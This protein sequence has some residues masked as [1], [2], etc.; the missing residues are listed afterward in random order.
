M[1]PE[2]PQSSVI[3]NDTSTTLRKKTKLS[4]E[5]I[6]EVAPGE[7]KIPTNF[8]ME[9][10]FDIAGF[11]RHFPDGKGGLHFK[12]PKKITPQQYFTQRL[13]N[14]DKRFSRDPDFLFVAQYYVERYG[15]KRQIDISM[16]KGKLVTS[17]D[18]MKVIQPN[19]FFNIFKLIPGTPAYWKVFRNEIMAK[20][21]QLGPFHIFFTLSC[22]EMGWPEIAAAILQ[23]RNHTVSFKEEFW[24]GTAE[25]ILID[26]VPLNEY[27]E[28]M[29]NKSSLFM[30][31]VILITMMFDNRVKAFLKNILNSD[32]VEH[33]A[34]R[35]E[36]QV[37]GMPHVHGVLWLNSQVIDEYLLP[38]KTFD[39]N[40]EKLPNLIDAWSTCSLENENDKLNSIVKEVNIH[41]H[42]RC[43]Q[44]GQECRFDFPRLPSDQTLVA[45]PLPKE[46][47]DDERKS[48]LKEVKLIKSKLNSK[49]DYDSNITLDD[50]LEDIGIP[51]KKY[52]WALKISEKG[53]YVVLKRKVC[54][55]FVNNYRPSYMY[56]WQ[57]NI[58]IQVCLDAYSVVSYISDYFTKPD[59]GK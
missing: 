11:P 25:S 23:E 10:D 39:V 28:Q 19:D 18:G 33:Y 58:D 47:P 35:I 21:E 6:Y 52:L 54:E 59:S 1:F 5:I 51:K 37:R 16:Q 57:V 15:L 31:Q 34:Y 50:F 49:K 32:E 17:D 12:R 44:K 45:H 20:I 4:S 26:N 14:V 48:I 36:F 29:T 42:K 2:N 24:D 13:L 43:K 46:T 9:N 8:L 53:E 38:N 3:I 40:N 41:K 7:N 55:A 30:D 56:A 27:C 22:N